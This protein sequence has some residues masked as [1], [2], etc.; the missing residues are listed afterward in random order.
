MR[1]EW[2][3]Y[4]KFYESFF[5]KLCF[6]LNC[7]ENCLFWYSYFKK[8]GKISVFCTV[9]LFAP[10]SLYLFYTVYIALIQWKIRTTDKSV[11]GFLS[12]FLI[13][14]IELNP[15]LAFIQI[16]NYLSD[17]PLKYKTANWLRSFSP[18]DF[19]PKF[20]IFFSKSFTVI[21][22]KVVNGMFSFKK[23][24]WIVSGQ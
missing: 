18:K 2:L 21:E 10:I 19:L 22:N 4:Y 17:Q 11:V 9:L 23:C 14:I 16:E 1:V 13:I 20:F 15:S 8:C 3:N 5:V 24:R 12:F 6:C 7:Y